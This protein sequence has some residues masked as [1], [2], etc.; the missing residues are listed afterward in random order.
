MRA[1]Q[2]WAW[3]SAACDDGAANTASA[4]RYFVNGFG[5]HDMLGNVWVWIENCY[6]NS[7]SGGLGDGSAQLVGD[8][9]SRA[10]RGG[11]WLSDP[12][13]LRSTARGW[14]LQ[15]KRYSDVGFRVAK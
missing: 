11:P 10:P 13:F 9:G 2:S 14:G 3:D 1:Y 8:C 12:P 4:G 6:H 7:Y 15:A 5:L